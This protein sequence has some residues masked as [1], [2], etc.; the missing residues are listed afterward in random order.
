[1]TEQDCSVKLESMNVERTT[2][3]RLRAERH[4]ALSDVTRLRVVDLLA[5]GDASSSELAAQMD[6]AS[7]LLA[8]HLKVLESAG[9]VQARRSEGDRRRTY[10]SRVAGAVMDAG[11]AVSTTPA[12]VI[13][14]CTANSARSHLAA[15]LWSQASTI[16]ATSAG[17]H[18]AGRIDPGAV[19]AAERHDVALLPGASPRLVHDVAR[20]GDL[21]VTVCD[22]AHEELQQPSALHWSIPDPVRVGTDTAFDNAIDLLAARVETLAPRLVEAS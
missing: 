12:R 20:D 10:W 16:P 11:S 8:H 6:V 3:L 1:M 19:A 13:F 17:T 5:L 4:A 7:N 15:A 18:P 21:M 14:V 9:L 22:L 2:E